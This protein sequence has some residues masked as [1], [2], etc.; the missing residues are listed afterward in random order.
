MQSGGAKLSLSQ[1]SS[2][3]LRFHIM[4][5]I[6]TPDFQSREIDAQTGFGLFAVRPFK[7]GEAIY[8]FDYWSRDV[9]PMHLTNHSCDPNASFNAEGLLVALRDIAPGD[10][11]TYHYLHHPVPASPW[12]FK[13][14]CGSANCID[15]LQ[16][17]PIP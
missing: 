3:L 12:N 13:C 6:D 10:E 9:M 17:H 4:S 7:T 16:V 5:Y 2:V 11:I 15:W 1:K 8:R 14:T